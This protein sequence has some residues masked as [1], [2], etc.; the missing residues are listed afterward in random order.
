M[1]QEMFMLRFSE[2]VEVQEL[3]PCDRSADKPWIRLT[4]KD[5]VSKD[6]LNLLP[7]DISLSVD[8]IYYLYM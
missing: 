2:F 6:L 3:E 8:D 1:T 4:S 5:K 7:P